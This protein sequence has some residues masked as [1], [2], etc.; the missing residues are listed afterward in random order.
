MRERDCKE[1]VALSNEH[2]DGV[3]R[4]TEVKYSTWPWVLLYY[5]VHCILWTS[6][7]QRAEKER[8]S[9][10]G[11]TYTSHRSTSTFNEGLCLFSICQPP[12]QGPEAQTITVYKITKINK[13]QISKSGISESCQQLRVAYGGRY[14][15]DDT[16]W[17]WEG[18]CGIGK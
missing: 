11:H 16:R 12:E 4:N 3:S 15:G 18:K 1:R 13:G 2:G 7:D 8:E 6:R 14:H 10:Q 9:S 5:T 17:A